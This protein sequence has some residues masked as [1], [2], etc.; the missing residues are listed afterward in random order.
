MDNAQAITGARVRLVADKS[1]AGIVMDPPAATRDDDPVLT[2]SFQGGFEQKCASS[3]LELMSFPGGT[4]V[5]VI[6]NEAR[7]G[8]VTERPARESLGVPQMHVNFDDGAQ[9]WV[10]SSTLEPVPATPDPYRDLRTGRIQ[11]V[12]S[13]RR[14]LAHEKLNGRLANVIYSMET[15]ETQFLAYQFKPVLKLLE[16]P[17]NSLLIADEVGLGKTIEAGLIWTE[18]RARIGARNLVVVCPPHLREKWQMELSRR[19][20]VGADACDAE[21][22]LSHLD[23]LRE[24]PAHAF[25][26]ITSYH[27][28]RPP[29]GWDEE[30]TEA[31]NHRVRLAQELNRLSQ[32][33][34]VIDLL[35]VDE[36][37]YMRNRE[38]RT[39]ELGEMLSN[40]AAHR[41]FLSATPIQTRSENLFNLLRLLD[42][43]TFTDFGTFHN[44]L[45]AN[46][47]LVRLR[48]LLLMP[49]AEHTAIQEQLQLATLNPYL[50][51]SKVLEGL[52]REIVQSP[53]ILASPHKRSELAYRVERVNL[54]GHAVNRTRKRDVLENRVIREVKTVRVPLTEDERNFYDGVT[55]L[56]L[57]Y[58]DEHMLS[59]GFLYV[60]PQRQVASCMAAACEHW[61]EAAS[62]E[63]DDDFDPDFA[64]SRGGGDGDHPLLDFLTR[65]ISS[66]WTPR[67]LEAKDSKYGLLLKTLREYWEGN[68]VEKV[69]L[70]SYFRPTLH[71]LRRRLE[72]DGIASFL[73]TGGMASD[74]QSIID[75]FKNS[76]RIKLLLSSEVGGEGL[77]IQF[78]KVLIN[79]DLPWNPMVVEQRIGRLDRIGQEAD[80][81]LIFNLVAQDTIDER[82]YDRL[83]L[84]LDLFRRSLGDL[85]DVVGPI[86]ASLSR[87]LLTHRLTPEQQ[88]QRI[89][90]AQIAIAVGIQNNEQL[91]QEAGLLAAYGDYII[92]QIRAS[93]ELQQW[94][95]AAEIERYVLDFFHSHFPSSR[96]QG[97]DATQRL[98]EVEL[99]NDAVYEFD[100]FL[101]LQKL[102]GITR[103]NTSQR[104]R[105]RFDNRHYLKPVRGEE[106]ITQSHPLVRFASWRIRTERSAACVPVAVRIRRDQ[107]GAG[108]VPGRYVFNVQRWQVTGLREFERLHYALV[109]WSRQEP[110]EDKQVVEELVEKAAACGEDWS[111]AALDFDPNQLAEI[112]QTIDD[113][114]SEEFLAFEQQ[115]I[116]ENE[117]RARV[118]LTS[119]DRFEERRLQRLQATLDRHLA[120]G[121]EALGEATKGQIARLRERCLLQR[122]AIKDRSTT[123]AEY[124][125]ICFGVIEVI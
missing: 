29:Q 87:D 8:K 39:A 70:F 77:D 109:D 63:D 125:Q 4:R 33:E 56:V 68:P 27:G 73:L 30:E 120:L 119:V 49:S 93:H 61:C 7:T 16:S 83:Y 15:S 31:R 66:R 32:Q 48:D 37:H 21:G 78:A 64:D 25:Q 113:H 46:V 123:N 80:R 108:V 41:V 100:R 102:A 44:I 69:V 90:Q 124:H 94:I 116:D 96:F 82:I 57:Q 14:N 72:A 111:G 26:V 98:Y 1:R 50:V 9:S 101:Q 6:G 36:A 22:L 103:L 97:V 34:P 3:E 18:L 74:K 76:K 115:C 10:R 71:Y 86:I 79:F 24:N 40:V 114:A 122:R 54:L 62:P 65:H 75:S 13:L 88:R 11:G 2:I 89:E 38:T 5:R 85:E 51:N 43:D 104:N 55:N 106:I 99:D 117:D 35:V 19:F 45:E 81:I 28:L 118:Q 92:R 110:V 59:A 17:N 95:K 12:G 23:R 58:A 60:M 42:P 107:V 105:V 52:Q 112:V 121:R 84:R 67:K 47:P 91:E 53:S 20:G